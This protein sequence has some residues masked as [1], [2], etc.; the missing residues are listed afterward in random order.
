M[1]PLF[2]TSLLAAAMWCGPIEP[3]SPKPTGEISSIS[4]QS[5]P[6]QAQVVRPEIGTVMPPPQ[7]S[8]EARSTI[9]VYLP[10]PPVAP[11]R[12]LVA[13]RRRSR[14]A[15]GGGEI[16]STGSGQGASQAAPP[17]LSQQAMELL[18]MA[19]GTVAFIVSVFGTVWFATK[20][21]DIFKV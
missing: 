3:P 20:M 8:A 11:Q 1:P 12:G 10:A 7:V 19:F 21:R 9:T 2:L 18:I 14:K 15:S 13:H 17:Y 16:P 6:S 5:A 4:P